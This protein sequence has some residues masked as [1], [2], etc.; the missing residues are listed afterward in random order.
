M[1]QSTHIEPLNQE[2]V[3][4]G[5]PLD[6]YRV[7][8]TYE[9]LSSVDEL[10]KKWGN[11]RVAD[12]FVSRPFH[13]DDSC[14]DMNRTPGEKVFYLH[15]AGVDWRAL[16]KIAWGLRQRSAIAPNGYRPATHEET[17]EFAKAHP[18]LVDFVGLGSWAWNH[19]SGRC[20][21][22]VNACVR[23][24]YGGRRILTEWNEVNEMDDREVVRVLFVAI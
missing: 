7:N 21:C 4:Q 14:R 2:H 23:G 5:L 8:V 6:H 11:P 15:Y 24:I 16:E 9:A 22:D 19:D 3:S 1:C 18:E 17:Y 20:A 12:I 13:L 10:E